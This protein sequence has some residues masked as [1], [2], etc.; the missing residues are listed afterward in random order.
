MT[1]LPV[2]ALE[3]S[4]T[5]QLVEVILGG[6]SNQAI[7]ARVIATSE[8]NPLFVTQVLSMFVD[9]GLIDFDGE[10][11]QPTGDLETAAVPPTIQALLAARL[12]DLSREER[13]VLEPASVIGLAFAQTAIEEL[14]PDT[15]RLGVAGH[16]RM[17][18]RKQFVALESAD[19]VDDLVYRFRN[20]MIKDATYGSLLKRARAQFH[21]RFVDWAERVN[22][23]R[24][25]EQ[26]FEEI[27]GYHLEQAFRYRRELGQLDEAAR[28]IAI[29]ATA[30]LGAAGRRA[31][32]RGDLPA[33][34]QPASSGRRRSS[35]PEDIHRA[36]LLIDLAEVQVEAGEFGEA[37]EILDTATR[38][39]DGS[40]G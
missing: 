22:R 29:R 9:K 1:H 38:A 2:A 39:A 20:L 16:L 15:V 25:R 14:V 24:G 36:E 8:G 33:A 12:D 27:L 30:K 26:E 7:D 4:A 37:T 3:P 23:E 28:D 6:P 19:A 11:W 40:P 32:A 10:R 13:V 17:L 34:R 35:S 31:F 21:E 5:A 18:D